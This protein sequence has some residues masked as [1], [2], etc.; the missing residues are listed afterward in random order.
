[1]SYNQD[2]VF[3]C[4]IKGTLNG[5]L[6]Q[7]TREELNEL[8]STDAG[9][10]HY[11]QE[12]QGIRYCVQET[13]NYDGVHSY[14]SCD[15][16]DFRYDMQRGYRSRTN[17]RKAM[18]HEIALFGIVQKD[19]N[20][21]DRAVEEAK[22]RMGRYHVT[23]DMLIVAPQLLLYIAVA[24]DEKI[25]YST[26]GQKAVDRFEAGVDGYVANAFRGLG[27]FT[28]VP[29]ENQETND[30]I[31]LLE[32]N[33]QIGEF[34]R[35]SPPQAW[36]KT[37]TLPPQYMGKALLAIK[38]AYS[39]QRARAARLL[40]HTHVRVCVCVCVCV[41]RV[42]IM[43]YDE[44]RDQ[45]RHITFER[46]LYACT[47]LAAD[48][49][50]EKP[51]TDLQTNPETTSKYAE[52]IAKIGVL[53]KAKEASDDD[54]SLKTERKAVLDE[55]KRLVSK[56]IYVPVCITI[57]R[58]FIE[59][60]MLSAVVTVAGRGTGATLFGPADMQVSA[61]TSV[62]TI[63]GHYTCHVKSAITRPENVLVLRDIMCTGYVA[64]CNTLFFGETDGNT[65]IDPDAVQKAM[66]E[67]LYGHSHNGATAIG[68][69]MAFLSMV[70]DV[71]NSQHDQVVTIT[72]RYLPWDTLP[73][74]SNASPKPTT[75]FPG[76]ERMYGVL[77]EKFGLDQI[78]EGED[79]DAATH[80]KFLANSQIYNSV[81]FIG[82][83]RVYSPWQSNFFEIVP[84][85]GHFGPDALPGVCARGRN[86]ATPFVVRVGLVC[87][88][89]CA[90]LHTCVRARV[91]NR[92]HAGDAAKP[93]A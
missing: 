2:V 42:Y 40:T 33:T 16:Y 58:P 81:C 8:L 25:K 73:A 93:S 88:C 46:A 6:K 44:E 23:P 45:L 63:E 15:N 69:M 50:D 22:Y 78:H 47:L 34:Y 14:L 61:N 29:F 72:N 64:G 9:R 19:E 31:Q 53:T 13:C 51:F 11:R 36:D 80:A 12:L 10:E 37:K 3:L 1:M 62:K 55:L 60:T 59:H 66:T 54:A 5:L 48:S 26:G 57:A 39:H 74:A 68:S 89:T 87:A 21:F 82:P 20:G 17:I 35:M 28:S 83:H 84:G 52:M 85:Q 76:G 77:K 67:R 65:Y 38:S 7:A 79:T 91:S 86:I 18:E 71:P 43:I 75:L 90:C 56:G 4:T 92:M 24:P 32:R 27:V 41:A 49:L 70:N 30:N